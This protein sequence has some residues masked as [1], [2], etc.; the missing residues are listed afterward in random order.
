MPLLLRTLELKGRVMALAHNGL[1]HQG[2]NETSE[3]TVFDEAVQRIVGIR[4]RRG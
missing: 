3:I 1:R 2:G 4:Q